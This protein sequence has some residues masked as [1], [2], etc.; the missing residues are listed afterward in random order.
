MSWS[1]V[2]AIPSRAPGCLR[3]I[4]LWY[5][6]LQGKTIMSARF[7]ATGIIIILEIPSQASGCLHTESV[8]YV[9]G[10]NI[11]STRFSF[12]QNQLC[13][14]YVLDNTVTS[15]RFPA[16]RINMFVFLAI[17]SQAPGFPV[18]RINMSVFLAIPSHAPGFPVHR[19]NM[20]VFLAIPSHAPSFPVHR[21]N[22]S[23]FLA[24]PS[25][26][27]GCLHTESTCLCSRQYHHTHHN[28]CTQNQPVCALGNT[29]TRTRLPAHIINMSMFLAIPSQVLGCLHT[30]SVIYF[31]GNTNTTTRL[32]HPEHKIA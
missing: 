3:T 4:I 17:P 18:H 6:A 12:T 23:V 5:R 10:N 31:L 25:H 21:I 22:M 16:H 9:L 19:I 14:Q 15:T 11:T 24:I 20:C 29:I 27:P 28:A 26:A 7:P 8:I 30:E 1:G 32:S 13:L 2:L